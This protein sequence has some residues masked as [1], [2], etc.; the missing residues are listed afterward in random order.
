MFGSQCFG[1]HQNII[2]ETIYEAAFYKTIFNTGQRRLK[3]Q[4]VFKLASKCKNTK[5]YGA[6]C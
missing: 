2:K 3:R 6:F 5:P 4:S 1:W